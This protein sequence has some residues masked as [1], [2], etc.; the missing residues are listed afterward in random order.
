[1][2]MAMMIMIMTMTR[3]HVGDAN[4]DEIRKATIIIGVT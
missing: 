3:M 4:S 1:M 2:M